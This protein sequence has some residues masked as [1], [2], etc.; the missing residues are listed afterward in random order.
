MIIIINIRKNR[1]SYQNVENNK[2]RNG[3]QTKPHH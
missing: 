3:K 1:I 2:V